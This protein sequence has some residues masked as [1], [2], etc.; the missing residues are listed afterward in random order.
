MR[1]IVIAA[2]A[3]SATVAHAYPQYQL[4]RDETCSA[5]HLSPAGGGLLSENGLA[6]AEVLSQWGTAPEFLNALIPT[7]KWLVLGGDIRG[8]TGYAQR[9][10]KGAL[11]TFPMQAELGVAAYAN[12]LSLHVTAGL[13]D[14][15]TADG[16]CP[17]P[18]QGYCGY[19]WSTLFGSREHYAMWQQRPGETTGLFVRAGRFMPVYGLRFAEHP[20]YDRQWGGT[21]LYGEAYA[22]AVEYVNAKWE[23]HATA[24]THDPWQ[25]TVELGTG[26]TVYGEARVDEKTSVGLES[27]VDVT[28]D[29][30][31]EYFGATGKHYFESQKLL[32]QGEAE[33]VHQKV[34]AGGTANGTVIYL[35]GTYFLGA[36]MIDLGLGLNDPNVKYRYLDMEA[37]DLNIHWFATSHI[38]LIATNR[39]QGCEFGA[40]CISSGWSLLQLHYRL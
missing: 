33:F 39:I 29:D 24:F 15:A 2:I 34:D 27:K 18:D 30:R 16:P 12:S 1:A 40:G 17:G 31:K 23:L 35:L 19:K 38:E 3:L 14:P 36:V 4:S 22:A 28:K 10:P 8:A 6:Q 11:V 26:G 5:C 20:A 37:A 7:P 21:P 32:L 25:S 9:E 13:Q